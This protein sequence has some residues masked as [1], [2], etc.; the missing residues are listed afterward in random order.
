MRFPGSALHGV[1][2]PA[3]V[4]FSTQKD[5]D[6]DSADDLD[7]EW[8]EYYHDDDD[9]D[10]DDERSVILF[11]TW[12]R[13][14]DDDVVDKPVGPI[15][16]P[17]DP[18]FH[19]NSN[20]GIVDMMMSSVDMEGVEVDEDF[21]K[22]MVEYAKQQKNEQ[23]KDWHDKYCDDQGTAIEGD[24]TKLAG[25]EDQPLIYSK[26][27][28]QPI[29]SWKRAEIN[30]GSLDPSNKEKGVIRVPLMGDET[31]RR[32]PRKKA[33]WTVSSSFES[34]V[35]ESEKPCKFSLQ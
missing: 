26:V 24:S 29:E 32:Y 25:G 5:E 22:G 17:L 3:D 14:Q 13:N 21:V 16:V 23:L 30:S 4:W 28:C 15:G 31:R 2:K 10:D 11:N 20:V 35:K 27:F 8:D 19:I 9:D 1:P 7:G 18:M 6:V 33:R 34:G 12:E